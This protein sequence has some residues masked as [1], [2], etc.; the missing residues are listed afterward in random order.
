MKYK[1]CFISW[2]W[3]HIWPH[4]AL[5]PPGANNCLDILKKLR[6]ANQ[7]NGCVFFHRSWKGFSISCPAPNWLILLFKLS[8]QEE[9]VNYVLITIFQIF[10]LMASFSAHRDNHLKKNLFKTNLPKHIMMHTT[11]TSLLQ[12]IR[13]K[14]RWL[15]SYKYNL[16]VSI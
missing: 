11:N 16:V 15:A 12:V 7:N 5:K 2:C 13:W 8:S 1:E 6:V 3:S 14:L 4:S 10:P 9:G